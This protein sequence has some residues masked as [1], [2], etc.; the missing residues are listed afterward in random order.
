MT[1][2]LDSTVLIDALRKEPVSVAE[3]RRLIQGGDEL[4]ASV[5]SLGEVYS[6]IRPHERRAVEQLFEEIHTYPV[7][8]AIAIRAG[9]LRNTAVRKG[10]TLKLD[11][12]LIAATALE[13]GFPVFTDNLKDFKGT[14]A[15]LYKAREH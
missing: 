5:I 7:T 4:A 1:I 3:L 11:D 6:G 13:L 2:L 8:I 15:V 9:E 14:G 12:M 10:R